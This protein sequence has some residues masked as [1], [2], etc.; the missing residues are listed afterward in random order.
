M[1]RT[2]LAATV[3][4][5][6]VDERSYLSAYLKLKDHIGDASYAREMNHRLKAMQSGHAVPR[7]EVADLHARLSKNGL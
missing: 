5:L 7:E 6:T 2:E 3:D 1:N 4:K